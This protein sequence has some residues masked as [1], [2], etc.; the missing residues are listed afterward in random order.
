MVAQFVN[1]P[2]EPEVSVTMFTIARHCYF[3]V[4]VCVCV[5][6]PVKYHKINAITTEICLKVIYFL[7]CHV[8]RAGGGGGVL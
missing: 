8:F 6:K 5:H 2:L 7:S 1:F 4:C 3:C